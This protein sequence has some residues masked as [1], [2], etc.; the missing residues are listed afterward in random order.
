MR[1]MMLNAPV[2]LPPEKVYDGPDRREQTATANKIFNLLY[3]EEMTDSLIKISSRTPHDSIDMLVWYWAGEHLWT[4][5]D[6]TGGLRY[7]EKALP[8]TYKLGDPSL[9]SYCERLVGLFYFR[10]SDYQKAIAH[11]SKSLEISQKAGD[12][13]SVGSALNTLAGIC[14]AAKQLNEAEKYIFEATRYCEEDNDSNLLPIRY[15]MASEI[16]HAKGE[17]KK[18]LAYARHANEIDIV[19]HQF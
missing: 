7:A 19:S 17:D 18:S 15:G 3:R 16:Y 1:A 14:L 9:Q 8:L 10:Q 2:P 6:Y 5:Q 12:K 13:S 4:T 11:V